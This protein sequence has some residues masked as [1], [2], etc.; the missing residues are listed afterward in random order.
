MQN[1]SV[2]RIAANVLADLLVHCQNTSCDATFPFCEQR[3]HGLVCGDLA[4]HMADASLHL[5]CVVGK[6][7]TLQTEHSALETL[8]S[9][10]ENKQSAL[11]NKYVAVE[12]KHSVLVMRYSALEIKHSALDFDK[13]CRENQ[14]RTG[15]GSL[16]FNRCTE[17]YKE[18]Y[19]SM[20]SH[21]TPQ[22]ISTLGTAVIRGTFGNRV[23]DIQ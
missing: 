12:N 10:L 11:E 21:R 15:L 5:A 23:F 16:V 14:E 17:V 1:L 6:L 7:G 18:Y 2:A 13:H 19:C 22:W 4:T 20:N 3:Q 8:H 9:A